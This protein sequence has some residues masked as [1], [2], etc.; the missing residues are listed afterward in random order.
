MV[1]VR[2]LRYLAADIY[3]DAV[4]WCQSVPQVFVGAA[5]TL[6]KPFAQ[7]KGHKCR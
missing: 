7:L 6:D 3:D 2:L 4:G 5:K 1:M